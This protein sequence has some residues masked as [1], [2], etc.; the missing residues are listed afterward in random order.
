MADSTPGSAERILILAP[1]PDDAS[2][3]ERFLREASYNPTSAS[4]PRP[5]VEP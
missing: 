3:C 2:L 5:S 4:T 1:S